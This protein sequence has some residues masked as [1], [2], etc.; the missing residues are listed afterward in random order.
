MAEKAVGAEWHAPVLNP[1]EGFLERVHNEPEHASH[2]AKKQAREMADSLGNH[3]G[4]RFSVGHGREV[5]SLR[6]SEK[7]QSS[8]SQRE[9]T[10]NR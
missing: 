5:A 10:L 7:A 6:H 8:L 3:N 4:W 9:T 2:F 1:L